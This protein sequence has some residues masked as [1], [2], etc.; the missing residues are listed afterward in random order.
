MTSTYTVTVVALTERDA[1]D[2]ARRRAAEDGYRAVRVESVSNVGA[3]SRMNAMRAWAVSL[4]V[5]K[6]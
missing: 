2:I 6:A 1:G 3:P 4:A 5:V